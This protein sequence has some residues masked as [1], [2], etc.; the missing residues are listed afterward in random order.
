[1]PRRPRSDLAGFPLHV[2]Q[3]GNNRAPCFLSDPDRLAYLGSLGRYALRH[4]V[5]VHAWVLMSNHVHLLLTAPAPANVSRLLQA[6]GRSYVRRFND[7]YERSG[8]LWEGRFRACAVH[9]ED[10][11]LACMRYIELNPV[12]AGL[13]DDPSNYRWSSY[14]GNALAREDPLLSEHALFLRLGRTPA[15]RSRAYRE[16]FQGQIA[17]GTL[18]E[19]RG[20]TASGHLLASKRTRREIEV[21][22]GKLLGPA[23]IGRPRK[24]TGLFI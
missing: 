5:A 23:P 9:A 2:I 18:V 4:E 6:V 11:L 20:A 10:Y 3:R 22:R 7:T 17:E 24:V 15:E 21:S 14:G 8:T 13:A 16:L 1:M 19:I 12:R